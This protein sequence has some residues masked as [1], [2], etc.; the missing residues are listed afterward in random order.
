MGPVV[1]SDRTNNQG[2]HI[3]RRGFGGIHRSD[4]SPSQSDVHTPD[5]PDLRGRQRHTALIVRRRALSASRTALTRGLCARLNENV[6]CPAAACGRTSS[7]LI[8]PPAPRSAAIAGTK[9]V[10]DPNGKP[11]PSGSMRYCVCRRQAPPRPV[12]QNRH[13]INI[14]IGYKKSGR[15]IRPRLFRIDGDYLL[16]RLSLIRAFLPVRLRR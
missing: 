8:S 9:G 10:S 2:C 6:L 7:L 13:V 12:G 14:A 1:R 4:Y 5:E 3:S 16:T 11:S 15:K